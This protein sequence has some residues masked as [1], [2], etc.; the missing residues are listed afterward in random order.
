MT[1]ETEITD[2]WG[3]TAQEATRAKLLSAIDGAYD[4]VMQTREDAL[5]EGALLPEE[6]KSVTDL[7]DALALARHTLDPNYPE[8]RPYMSDNPASTSGSPAP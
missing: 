7:I 4:A 5:H 3:Q 1:A 2:E 6:D 8:P